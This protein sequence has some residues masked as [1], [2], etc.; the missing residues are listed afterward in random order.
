M[1]GSKGVVERAT[2]IARQLMDTH[3]PNPLP[4]EAEVE[5]QKILV[6]AEAEKIVQ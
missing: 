3:Q 4:K 1:S 6:A 2:E 5:L